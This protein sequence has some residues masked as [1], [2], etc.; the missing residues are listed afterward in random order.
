VG[1]ENF[2]RYYFSVAGSGAL[3][4]ECCRLVGG[5][6]SAPGHSGRGSYQLTHPGAP[7]D[8]V[9]T[10]ARNQDLLIHGSKCTPIRDCRLVDQ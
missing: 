2:Q 9:P 5:R 4:E 7:M 1:Q 3:L 8:V 6:R 10:P